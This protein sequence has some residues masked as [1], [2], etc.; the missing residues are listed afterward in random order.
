MPTV[1]YADVPE[2]DAAVVL[3]NGRIIYTEDNDASNPVNSALYIAEETAKALEVKLIK[4]EIDNTDLPD[5]W[6][7]DD[8]AEEANNRHTE[9]ME[10]DL[11]FPPVAEGEM[12]DS[13]DGAP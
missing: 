10:N 12:T 3:V 8:F 11:E 2:V 6:N 1:L 13:E 4:M 9:M 5:D 7:F